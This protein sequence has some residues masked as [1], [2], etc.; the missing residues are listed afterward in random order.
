MFHQ[1]TDTANRLPVEQ[2]GPSASQEQTQKKF[3]IKIT[4][5]KNNFIFQ[6]QLHA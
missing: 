3:D 4:D 5:F 6:D 2:Q 1:T